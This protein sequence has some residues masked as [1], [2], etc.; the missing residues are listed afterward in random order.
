[1][2]QNLVAGLVVVALIVM[3]VLAYV[4]KHEGCLHGRS[5]QTLKPCGSVGTEM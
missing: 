4:Q 5:L 1:M 2:V 3:G